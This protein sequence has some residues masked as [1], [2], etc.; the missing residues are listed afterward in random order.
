MKFLI[1]NIFLI[2]LALTSGLMLIW[3][4]IFRHSGGARNISPKEAVLMMNRGHLLVIDV[5]DSADFVNGHIANAMNVPLS[6]IPDRL[7]SITKYKEKPILVNCQSGIRSGKACSVL[8]K[9]GFNDVYNLEGGI[10][11]WVEAKL[12]I[13]KG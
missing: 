3:P 7:V 5:R 1:D 10:T 11:G 2:G 9:N 13:M 8:K 4:D 12:P 6:E